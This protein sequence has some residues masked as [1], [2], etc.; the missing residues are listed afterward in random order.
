MSELDGHVPNYATA[1][2]GQLATEAG[3]RLLADW[4]EGDILNR[5]PPRGSVAEQVAA[6]EQEVRAELTARIRAEIA[7]MLFDTEEENRVVRLILERLD[8]IREVSDG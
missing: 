5:L 1:A 8:A 3:R 7:A 2:S 4:N 6:I